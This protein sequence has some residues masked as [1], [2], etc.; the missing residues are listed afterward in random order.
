M[1]HFHNR[2]DEEFSFEDWWYKW[3]DTHI[4]FYSHKTMKW[5]AEEFGLDI[6]FIA[7]KKLCVFAKK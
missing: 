6:L 3:D 4:S 7:K 5:I 2:I 1:T